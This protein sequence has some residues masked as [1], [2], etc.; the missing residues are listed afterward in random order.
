M[1]GARRVASDHYERE[2]QSLEVDLRSDLLAGMTHCLAARDWLL[3][4]VLVYR[5]CFWH[6][7]AALRWRS[8]VVARSHEPWPKTKFRIAGKQA[9]GALRRWPWRRLFVRFCRGNAL[10]PIAAR[11][12]TS[13]AHEFALSAYTGMTGEA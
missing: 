7:D 9:A 6:V 1:E 2:G 12:R 10:R 11:L 5:R 13:V 8:A 3:A 4:A